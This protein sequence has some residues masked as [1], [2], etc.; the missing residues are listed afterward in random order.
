MWKQRGKT[1]DL[2]RE[3]W[4]TEAIIAGGS[5][6]GHKEKE[7]GQNMAK[8][9]KKK[10]WKKCITGAERSFSKLECTLEFLSETIGTQNFLIAQ[11]VAEAL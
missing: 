3:V 2:D 1:A 11:L 5:R 6:E 4:R 7:K 8:S 9:E 10:W